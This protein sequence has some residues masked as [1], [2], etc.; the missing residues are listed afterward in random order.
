VLD[1]LERML[2]APG[3]FGRL[4]RVRLAVWTAFLF[5]RAS[6]WTQEHIVP[7]FDWS[8]ADAGA[9][10]SARKYS[11]YI[12]SPALFE[13]TKRPLLQLF[14][15]T[16]VAAQDLGIFADW[17]VAIAIANQSENA[18]Y[19]ISSKEIRSALRH[20][21]TQTLPAVSHRLAME[22]E[23]AAP[24]EKVATWRKVVGPVFQSIWPLDVELQSPSN[25]FK[26]VQLLRATGAAFAEAAEL[27][28]PFIRP[29]NEECHTSVYS[30]SEADEAMYSSSPDKVLDLL[31]AVV[32]EDRTRTVFGIGKALDRLGKEAPQLVG[33]PKFQRLRG[34]DVL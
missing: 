23:R 7:L 33:S 27:I 29:E 11:N 12:G 13:L 22:M 25:T 17:L 20:A 8:F 32:G 26:L 2:N 31:A 10:W 6:S 14:A 5:E 9:M 21:A 30:L 3:I 19:P 28:V 1:R 4:A 18:G 16:D 15:R 34:L 24:K